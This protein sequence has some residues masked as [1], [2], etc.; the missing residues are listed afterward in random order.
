MTTTQVYL[1]PAPPFRL[2]LTAWALRR[3]PRNT[4]DRWDGAEYSR[5][6]YLNG[7][8]VDLGV[9]QSG[10]PDDPKL[11]IRITHHGRA[12]EASRIRAVVRRLLGL[13]VDMSDFYK[14]AAANARLKAL[15][16]KFRGFRPPCFPTVFEAAVNAICCQ[17][18]SLEVGIELF[19]RLAAAARTD[20]GNI[21]HAFPRPCEVAR[22]SEQKLH[23]LGFSRQK[24]AALLGLARLLIKDKAYLEKLASLD[25]DSARARLLDIKGIGRWSADYILL[26]GMGRLSSFPGDDIAAQA[27]LQRWLGIKGRGSRS[28]YDRIQRAL[29]RYHPFQGLIYF[30]LLLAGLGERGVLV[31]GQ[32]SNHRGTGVSEVALSV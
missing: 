26:R 23:E 16:D 8:L 12:V 10:P 11:V 25:D 9:K 28:L 30:H 27:G 14:L 3:R 31:P 13:S 2:D 19:N 22:L 5:S 32:D 7:T 1:R 21:G 20:A 24:I 15:A 17:Q 6:L 18:L 4:I 29:R